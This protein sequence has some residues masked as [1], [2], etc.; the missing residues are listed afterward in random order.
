MIHLW[1]ACANVADIGS[2]TATFAKYSMICL[3]LHREALANRQCFFARLAFP[4]QRMHH[5]LIMRIAVSLWLH[6]DSISKDASHSDSVLTK[7]GEVG[8]I[9]FA[10][11]CTLMKTASLGGSPSRRIL[12]ADSGSGAF[13]R[14][15]RGEWKFALLRSSS[16]T[17][18]KFG[19]GP[20]F[21]LLRSCFR[22][23]KK[24]WRGF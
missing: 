14:S 3:F 9:G 15:L 16:R 1:L 7:V 18:K 6:L 12:C 23:T 11:L 19:G 22:T 10:E 20:I 13:F 4:Y 8:A 21:A 5:G 2:T 24:F 17:S